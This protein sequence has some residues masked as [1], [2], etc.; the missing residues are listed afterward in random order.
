MSKNKFDRNPV[1][2]S[3]SEF[4]IPSSVSEFSVPDSIPEVSVPKINPETEKPVDTNDSAA[5][6]SGRV[7]AEGY[8]SVRLRKEPNE[9]AEVVTTVP[10]GENVLIGETINGWAKVNWSN[11]FS[12]W[13]MD[14]YIVRH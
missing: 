1:P 10:V 11:L 12:G 7:C 8:K 14:K 3:V 6:S 9:N 13:M 2:D 4:S 5:A